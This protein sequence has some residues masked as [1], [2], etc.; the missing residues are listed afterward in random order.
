MGLS[1]VRGRLWLSRGR[2]ELRGLQPAAQSSAFS[3]SLV[4]GRVNKALRLLGAAV[5]VLVVIRVL[6]WL[7]APALPLLVAL[8]I[9][10]VI[11]RLAISG[12]R[13]L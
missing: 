6:A 10:G 1:G 2:P 5:L 8:L 4:G 13:G 12:R 11:A 9:I 7:L 3:R